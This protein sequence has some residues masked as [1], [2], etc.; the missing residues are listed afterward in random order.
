MAPMPMARRSIATG[1]GP[2]KRRRCTRRV[3]FTSGRDAN[4]TSTT[5]GENESRAVVADERLADVYLGHARLCG[6]HIKG[7]T[8]S[9][10]YHRLDRGEVEGGGRCS[11]IGSHGISIH[12]CSFLEQVLLYQ[13][14]DD[15]QGVKT[16]KPTPRRGQFGQV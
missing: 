2:K 4:T 1:I 15:S 12:M 3:V 16:K 9:R 8:L 7:H 6:E 11:G 14:F 5:T 13:T 10:H